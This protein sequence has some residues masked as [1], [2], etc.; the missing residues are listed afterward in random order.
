MSKRFI[1]SAVFALTLT[2]GVRSAE[3]EPIQYT[4]TMQGNAMIGAQSFSNV[5][6]TIVLTGDTS[7]VVNESS[8]SDV[9]NFTSVEYTWCQAPSA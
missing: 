6:L 4:L 8:N 9:S 3:A 1:A 5:L 2:L 7:N